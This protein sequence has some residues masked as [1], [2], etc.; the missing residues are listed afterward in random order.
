MI[1]REAAV[2]FEKDFWAF[3]APLDPNPGL[4]AI[5]KKF[6]Y[7]R[8]MMFRASRD[9]DP[10]DP[11]EALMR[12]LRDLPHITW[13]G[14]V[15][16]ESWLRPK[17]SPED[18]VL[19]TPDNFLAFIET[20]GCKEYADKVR[21]FVDNE[22]FPY[23]P[24]M[25]GCDH[26]VSGGVIEALS[27]R[28]GA[29]N[30][31]VIIIDNHFDAILSSI[32]NDLIGWTRETMLSYSSP[33]ISPFDYSYFVSG[34]PDTYNSGSFV[35]YLI[36][37]QVIRPN[38]VIVIGA[39][40][41]PNESLLRE[42]DVRVRRFLECYFNFEKRGVKI[43]KVKREKECVKSVLAE[44]NTPYVYV[45]LDIDIG[46]LNAIAGC[47]TKDVKGLSENEIC[48]VARLINE[49]LLS[50]KPSLVGFDIVEIDVYEAG[51]I[52]DGIKDQTYEV[53]NKFV[54]GLL[55]NLI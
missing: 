51:K 18:L 5:Q 32:R 44:I 23:K 53:A 34:V 45:S 38:N 29:D 28:L 31:S 20:N 52:I 12:Y 48:E 42:K 19:L 15:Y 49:I 27:K 13:K 55:N 7:V 26:S 25:I 30:I 2:Q 39:S 3:G 1:N 11:Y 22:I 9:G 47:R 41:Y 17:P 36:E 35:Y 24:L 4:D 6:E 50:G 16:V 21:D 40:D 33:K 10:P 8:A 54:R 43:V 46:S 14:N 37:D